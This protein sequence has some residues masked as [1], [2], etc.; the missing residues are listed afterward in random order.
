M[1]QRTS[2]IV[3]CLGLVASL[4]LAATLPA[5]AQADPDACPALVEAALQAIDAA[6]TDLGRGEACYGH[7]RVEVIPWDEAS[8]LTFAAPADRV[9]LLDLHSLT[10]APLDLASEEWGVAVL[11]LQARV[12]GALPGQAITFLLMGDATLQNTVSPEEAA[13]PVEPVAAVVG[14]GSALNLRNGPATTYRILGAAQPGETL[15][16]VGISAARDWYEVILKGGR[17]WVFGQ[18]IRADADALAVLPV[19]EG[20]SAYGPMQAFYF[21]SGLSTL[22]CAEAP[23]SLVIQ[24][25]TGTPIAMQI[26]GARALIG[27]TVVLTRTQIDSADGPVTLLVFTLLEGELTLEINETTVTLTQPDSAPAALPTLAV[28]VNAEGWIDPASRIVAPPVEAIR[29]A[30]AESCAHTLAISALSTIPETICQTPLAPVEAPAPDAASEAAATGLDG[31][32]PGDLCTVAAG[33]DVNLRGGPGI[34]YAI[35]GQLAAGQ[36]AHPDGYAQGADG[37][38]WWRVG[39]DAWVRGDLMGLAGACSTLGLVQDVPTPPPALV[40][41]SSGGCTV[42]HDAPGRASF[43]MFACMFSGGIRLAANCEY[44]VRM[45]TGYQDGPEGEAEARAE[46]SIIS[47]PTGMNGVPLAAVTGNVVEYNPSTQFWE[48]NQ[49][50][51]TGLLTPGTYT[52]VGQ[53]YRSGQPIDQPTCVLTVR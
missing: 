37:L 9:P 50:Y 4:L 11:S 8:D 27:S 23:N 32:G 34:T 44:L 2:A 41:G 1:F 30:V 35:T 25:G 10:T 33:R 22:A 49:Y 21:S 26:N 47:L 17:A 51:T 52:L 24:N 43:N 6:C 12:E 3:A 13:Q 29:P 20:T 16:V 46:L 40:G 39:A 5:Q 7:T 15:A 42:L 28:T 38:N 53:A 31:I 18:G 19:T 14:P 36:R 48:I 45:S